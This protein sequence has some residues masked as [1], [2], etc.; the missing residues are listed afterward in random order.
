M[1][2]P[3][4]FLK[5]LTVSEKKK[6]VQEETDRILADKADKELKKAQI[7]LLYFLVYKKRRERKFDLFIAEQLNMLDGVNEE[8]SR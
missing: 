3:K 5:N 8:C 1:P 4:K 2:K 7:A 6:F